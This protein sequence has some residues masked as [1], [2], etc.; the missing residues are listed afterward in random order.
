MIL[1]K[2]ILE[3]FKGITVKYISAGRY[4]LETESEDIKIAD[5]KLREMITEAEKESKR[6]GVEFFVKEK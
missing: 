2:K 4:S 1:I 5:K 6:L 3:V